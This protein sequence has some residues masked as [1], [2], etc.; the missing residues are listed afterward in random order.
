MTDTEKINEII[1][2]DSLT[3]DQI[4]V[5]GRMRRAPGDVFQLAESIKR[6]GII[7]PIV[8]TR[9]CHLIAGGRRFAALTLLKQTVLR[10]NID[11]VYN[12]EEDPL[13]LKAM[14]L[15]ENL[16]RED[17]HWSEVILGKQQLLDIMVGIH[18]EA[19][20]G[21]RKQGVPEG[22][23]I[24]SLAAMLGENPSTTSRDLE[25]AAYVAKHPMLASLPTA[26]DARRKLGVAV[27][28]AMMQQ[29]A[30]TST[31]SGIAPA[32]YNSRPD[33]STVVGPVV[34]D[35][36]LHGVTGPALS[37]ELQTTQQVEDRW[38]L[39]EG[40]F[41][42]NIPQVA[43]TSVDLILTDLPYN[44]GLGTSNASHSAGLGSFSDDG[45]DMSVLCSEVAV[46]AYRVLRDDRFA[47]FFYGMNYHEVLY[48]CL[49]T[50]GFTVDPYPFIWLRDRTAPPDGFAR[51][52]KSYDPAFICSKGVPRFIRPNLANSLAV[53]SV[54]GS[55]RLH[56]AQ[57]PVAIMQK[58]IE[59]MTT[60]GCAVLD[61]FA[62]AG[63][64]GEASLR[65]GRKAIL[66]EL[67]ASN[68]L[69][70]RSRLGV[71]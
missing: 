42:D 9:K 66:F 11:F 6:Y 23:G 16:K 34:R 4:I 8:L 21:H 59:D 12:D 40:R 15:E 32:A 51:Y 45:I 38:C 24:R 46:E 1:K 22:F 36:A 70:I 13:R 62:G 18:G 69:L 14:E 58:F 44:I 63:T 49:T 20:A 2:G 47:V 30:K 37:L 48:D 5:T 33:I 53:P 56:A 55:E 27:T 54:R 3:L 26:A 50:A 67:E 65:T 35:A 60:P 57:K 52:S 41:Q 7:Q 17:L 39:Y 28:V 68:C 43:D 29:T 71:L 64:T 19:K 25:L 31:V 10:H 61:M